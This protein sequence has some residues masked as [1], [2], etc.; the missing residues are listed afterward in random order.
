[1]QV[2]LP[3]DVCLEA[4]GVSKIFCRHLKR[5]MWYGVRDIAR[6]CLG[7][8]GSRSELR[9]GE[10]WSLQDVDFQLQR[11]ESLALVGRNGAGKTT[12]LKL[13]HGLARPD[14]GYVAVRGRVGALIAL[15]AGFNPILSGRENIYIAGAVLGMRSAEID[16]RFDE[17]VDFAGLGEVIDAPVQTYSSGMA[18]RLG[19][20]VASTL[21][22][23]VLLIDEVLAVGDFAFRNKCLQRLNQL[24]TKGVAFILVTHAMTNVVQFC[25]RALWLEKGRVKLDATSQEVAARYVA[26]HN[27]GAAAG[28]LFGQTAFNH[29]RLISTRVTVGDIAGQNPCPVRHGTD[30]VIHF[31]FET[32]EAL[33]APN[34]SFPIYR[35]DGALMTTLATIAR[36]RSIPSRN[37]V[38]EGVVRFGP[39]PF[40][41]GDYTVV[42][43]LHD[44]TEHV[45]RDAV[46]RLRVTGLPEIGW[47]YVK[48]REEWSFPQRQAA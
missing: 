46:G 7:R 9:H 3:P 27:P 29:D 6:E 23:D 11:G 21:E 19:F 35:G 34:V 26:E 18:V 37:N 33:S 39:V 40:L 4:R 44:G 32:R 2:S 38:Y 13:I 14:Q 8:R 20:S 41:A 12:L 24:R 45:F 47:G 10:F 5:S 42:A 17:I 28:G 43:N 22:P 31:R 1:M 48:L 15:G 16:A 25:E 30:G 36:M